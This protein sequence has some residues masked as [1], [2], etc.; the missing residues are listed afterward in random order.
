MKTIISLVMV[1]VMTCTAVGA[2]AEGL[3]HSSEEA[4]IRELQRRFLFAVAQHI[5]HH[6][7]QNCQQQ[8]EKQRVLKFHQHYFFLTLYIH[9]CMTQSVSI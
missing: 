1:M 6:I 5:P 4:D 9:I 3:V 8:K 2:L 7:Q